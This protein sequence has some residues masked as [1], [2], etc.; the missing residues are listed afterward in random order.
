ML[1]KLFEPSDVVAVPL[2]IGGTQLSQIAKQERSGTNGCGEGFL[3]IRYICVKVSNQHAFH[4]HGGRPLIQQRTGLQR[5]RRS[6]CA[7][8]TLLIQSRSPAASRPASITC[9]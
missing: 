2:L 1:S 3:R 8:L 4:R 7:S 9:F 6:G 5:P